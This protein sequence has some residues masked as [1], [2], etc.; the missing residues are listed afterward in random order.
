[1]LTFHRGRAGSR[2]R[3]GSRHWSSTIWMPIMLMALVATGLLSGCGDN[4]AGLRC[5][6]GTLEINGVCQPVPAEPLL[7]PGRFQAPLVQLQRLQGQEDHMH[8]AQ[9]KY[10]EEDSKLFYCSYTFGMI[11]ASDPQS[12]RYEVEG[13]RHATPSGSR[14]TPGCLHLSWDED[15]PNIIY[16]THRGNIDFAL[17]LS[18]WDL[19]DPDVPVQLPALQESGVRYGGIDVEN[20]LIYVA[21]HEGG[22]GIYDYDSST[23]WSHISTA[24]GLQNAWNVQVVG[25]V[26]YVAD[27]NGG[28][29]TVDVSNPLAPAFMNRVVF[30]GNAEDLV[31]DRGTAYVAAGSAGMVIVD[32]SDPAAPAVMSSVATPGSAVGVAYAAGRAYVAAWND[33]RVYDVSDPASPSFVAALRLTIEQ[34]YEVC[35]GEPEVCVPD[36]KRP[37]PTARTL[38]VAAYD[39]YVFVGNWWVP[40]SFQVHADRKAPHIAIPEDVALIDFGPT[41]IG[42]SSTRELTIKNDG[43]A[44][45]TL[46]DNWTDT[47]A[48]TVSPPQVEIAPGE[49]AALTITYTATSSS[50]ET[51]G[52]QIWSDDPQ[53]PVRTGYMVGNRPGLG[54]GHALPDTVVTLFDDS[55]L[56]TA[57]LTGNVMVLA[58][59]ATF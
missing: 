15:D 16:T 6:E 52:L 44:P 17:F 1:M 27:G 8:I 32:A 2:R 4:V 22:L 37:D 40:Y 49:S 54:V 55:T 35:S 47:A 43:T 58:Y 19:T 41:A 13:L 12:M 26:A 57:D 25:D 51:G 18:G 28:L 31:V 21:L 23:G 59:F 39:D 46:F 48:F 53:Q 24:T 45:L 5:G 30:G 10:R 20:G 36:T 34:D 7:R 50:I 14:R 56:S 29:A 38:H 33:T 9:V 11:D 42:E 3:T